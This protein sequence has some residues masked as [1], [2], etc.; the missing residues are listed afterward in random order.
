VRKLSPVT[1]FGILGV[2]SIALLGFVLARAVGVIMRAQAT[3]TLEREAELVAEVGVLPQLPARALEHGLGSRRHRVL[4]LALKNK[5][6][7]HGGR[8]ISVWNS[9]GKL[10]YSTGGPVAGYRPGPGLAAAL[11]GEVTSTAVPATR[12]DRLGA[13]GDPLLSV[14]VPIA[15]GG[16]GA[17][18]GAVEVR[19]PYGPIAGALHEDS[20]LV[21][22]LLGAGLLLLYGIL[23]RIVA[24]ASKR[25]QNQVVE[26]QHQALHDALT[27]LPNR[28]LFRERVQQAINVAGSANVQLAVMLMD[29][30]R[31]KEVNDTLGHHYGDMLLKEV[32]PRLEGLLRDSDGVARLGGD[33]FA[34]L[35]VNVSAPGS[36]HV[37][38]KVRDELQQPFEINDLKLHVDASVGIALYP[39]HGRDVDTLLQRADVAMY[40]AKAGGSGVEVYAANRDSNTP[41]R[42]ALA[43]ELRD[44]I[45]T[46]ELTLHYQPKVHLRSGRVD[47]VEALV[48]W[49]HP[50]RGMIA[51][52]DFVPIAE[53]TGLIAR[54]TRNVIRTA[55]QQIKAWQYEGLNL[56]VAVNLSVRNLL[57]P[58]LPGE[59]EE[60][61]NVHGV[62]PA[63]LE[64]EITESSMMAEPEKA[65]RVLEQL[66]A[67]GIKIAID[68]FGTGHSSLAYLKRLPVHT[69]KIDKSFV[70][71]MATDENDSVIVQS[72][73]DLAHNLGLEVVAEGVESEEVKDRLRSLGCDVAQG[74]WHGRP[75]SAEELT[76]SLKVIA[77]PAG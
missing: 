11:R 24:R 63:N 45:N 57:D 16:P 46:D 32:G 56:T 54:L 30:D 49:K 50:M 27:G 33:E 53:N 34:M 12:R 29:L 25:L 3:S 48:R 65:H 1:R 23:F 68:D 66:A 5:M 43:A 21:Y 52:G 47:G 72:T 20:Y 41:G 37:A 19:V 6:S 10:V 58:E 59:V 69:L 73:I 39:Q 28:V 62:S 8:S 76:Y 60:L 18:R 51:P 13:P 2:L 71:N 36:V 14:Y 75:V 64:I 40:M 9:S 61:L 15:P 4:D 35:L 38:G 31:F 17:V 26:N 70:M 55:L 67:T 22:G 42:L 7:G 77:L 74:Y 44:A